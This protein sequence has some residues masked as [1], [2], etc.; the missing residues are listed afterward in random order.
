MICKVKSGGVLGVEG[1]EVEVE[2]DVSKGLP[3]FNIVGLPDSAIKESKERIRSALINSGFSFPYKRITV[4]LSPSFLKKSGTLYDLPIALG[5]L[6]SMGEIPPLGDWVV[7]GELSLDGKVRKV[8]GILPILMG[9][10]KLGYKRFL[11]PQ[12]NALEVSLIKG[13]EVYCVSS[14]KEAIS[15]LLGSLKLEPIPSKL[16]EILKKAQL[17]PDMDL[18][19]VYGQYLPKKALE[20]A[21]AGF[22]NLLMV[23]PPGAGK[24]MLAK[25][26]TT[27]MPPMDEEEVLEVSKI[28]SVFGEVKEEIITRRPFRSPHYTT[29]AVALIGGGNPPRPGEVSLAH[30]GVLFL[31]ELPEFGRK[32]LEAL[33]QPMEDGKVL[34]SRSGFKVEF[35][36]RFLLIGAMNPCP[37]GN[38]QNPYKVCTCSQKKIKEYQAKVSAP[39]LDR[40]DVRVWVEPL[41]EEELLHH[42]GGESSK[43]VRERVLK[44]Y[45]VQRERAGKFNAHLTDKELERFCTLKDS[46]KKLLR[47]ALKNLKLSARSYKRLLKVSRT[48]ADLEAEEKIGEEHLALALQL[49]GEDWLLNQ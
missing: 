13:V 9:L 2:V 19:E 40:I 27:I 16:E 43:E 41:K 28:Y 47:D 32:T 45:L 30:R 31:D 48:V 3:T 26:S 18:I 35:P 21:V 22:H 15:F 12:E 25:R 37:C 17:S 38:Y 1:F 8:L 42:R 14:L 49:R 24:S 6:I 29:S 11:V 23:G 36:A 10:K 5:I 44:A 46:A 34:I 39:L 20:V 33:R 7:L 4:N